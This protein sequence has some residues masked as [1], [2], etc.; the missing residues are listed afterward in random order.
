MKKLRE[1][2]KGYM[3]RPTLYKCVT[4]CA[5]ALAL[6]LLWGWFNGRGF[7]SAL[8]DGGFIAAAILLGAAWVSYL[9][10]DGIDL[11]WQKK[12]KQRTRHWSNSM[13]DFVDEHITSWDELTDEERH[14]CGLLSSLLSAVIFLIPALFLTGF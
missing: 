5:A 9:R 10:L 13:A 1:I 2:W 8:R 4:K 6:V 14:T 7:S 3:L 12:E 11:P